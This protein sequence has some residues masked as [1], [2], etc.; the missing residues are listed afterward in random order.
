M[1]LESTKLFF[2][3]ICR[4]LFFFFGFAKTITVVVYA[5]GGCCTETYWT[6][7]TEEKP[8]CRYERGGSCDGD[9]AR[10]YGQ[11][12]PPS[13]AVVVNYERYRLQQYLLPTRCGDRRKPL[14]IT[15]TLSFTR[16][17]R[18]VITP[19]GRVLPA[20]IALSTN[21]CNYCVPKAKMPASVYDNIVRI[22]KIR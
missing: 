20:S 9:G 17:L 10:L 1:R 4:C 22:V 7:A 6:K 13:R 5:F 19:R 2:R 8:R 18:R 14:S 21:V 11:R 16:S 3:W 15:L 12:G